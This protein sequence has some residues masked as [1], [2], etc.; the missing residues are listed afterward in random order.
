MKQRLL[1]PLLAATMVLSACVGVAAATASPAGA[2]CTASPLQGDWRNINSSTNAMTR[3][4][5]ETC[6]SVTTCNGNICQTTHDAA[7]FMT[8]YGKC[9]PTDCNWGRKQAEYMSDGWIR[10]IYYFGFKTSHVWA[11][12]YVYYGRTYLRLWVYNDFSP[13]DGRTDYTTDEWMLK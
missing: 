6:Q 10:S 12:T 13:T 5:I 7:T 11:K 3:I 4:V 8:P 1:R 9:H 2:L